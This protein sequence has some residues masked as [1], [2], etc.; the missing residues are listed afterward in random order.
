[1]AT[2]LQVNDQLP[3]FSLPDQQNE[4]VALSRFTNTI[5]RASRKDY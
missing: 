4:M 1:M 3:D 5:D 2:N